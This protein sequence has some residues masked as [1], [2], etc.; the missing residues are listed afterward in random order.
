MSKQAVRLCMIGAGAHASAQIYPCFFQLN[1]VEIVA[2]CDLDLE[3]ARSI[4]SQHGVHRHYQ[5]WREML[6]AENPDG[7]MLCIGDKAHASLSQEIMEAGYHVYVEKPHAPNLVA[8]MEMLRASEVTQK[9]CMGA[10][11]KRYTPAFLKAREF[12]TKEEFG[13]ICLVQGYRAMGG[14]NQVAGGFHWQW[15]CHMIDAMTWIGGPI[16][17]VHA[18]KNEKD[19]RATCINLRYVNGAVGNLI[20]ASP[21]GN[22]EEVRVLGTGMNAVSVKDGLFCTAYQGNDPCGGFTPSFSASGNSSDLQ[23]FRGEMQAFIDAIANG[24]KPDGD[25]RD[26]CHTAA[27]YEAI[28]RS[29]DSAQPERV[30]VLEAVGV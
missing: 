24:R 21:G 27:I 8:S 19:Y 14:N 6:T 11:K 3:R 17:E 10:Y 2:N 16:K 29:I 18:I 12:Y 26:L 20:L 22:W 9:I 7:V 1:N 13:D 15:G 25:I 4:G 28:V 23:G 30:E 5:D